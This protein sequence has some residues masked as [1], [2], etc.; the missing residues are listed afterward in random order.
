MTISN[1]LTIFRIVLVPVLVVLMLLDF[2]YADFYSAAVF[3]IASFTDFLDGYLARKRNEITNFGKFADPIA[4][5]VLVISAYLCLVE[6]Q[7]VPSWAVIIVLAREFIVSALRMAAAAQNCVIA[8]DKFGK[9]KTVVQMIST[10][11]L[12]LG[13]TTLM[14]DKVGV[15]Y[16]V[17]MVL[18]YISVALAAFSGISYVVKYKNLLKD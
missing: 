8:A 3:L 9:L 18:F 4:D 11:M 5:K 13:A 1:K 14:Q 16:I 17:A 15:Y 6:A 10:T 2:K 12:I 7:L